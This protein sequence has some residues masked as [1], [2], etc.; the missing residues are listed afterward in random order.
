MVFKFAYFVE[1]TKAISLQSFNAVDCLGK[2]LTEG[3]QKHNDGVI[4]TSFYTF[5]IRNFYIL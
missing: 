2:G 4:M 3:L 1:L 5:G